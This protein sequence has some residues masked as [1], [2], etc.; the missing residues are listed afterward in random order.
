MLS[1]SDIVDAKQVILITTR[2]EAE[3]LGKKTIKDNIMT[4]D[5]HSPLSFNPMLYGILIGRTRYSFNLI[6]K[7]KVFCVNFIPYKMKEK[8]I[9]C[10]KQR[11]EHI[12]KFN[13][14]VLKKDECEKIDCPRLKDAVAF[15]EC[16]V[17]NEIETGD[18]VLF[19]GRVVNSAIKKQDKRL[20]HIAGDKFTTTR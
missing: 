1:I 19:V 15:L 11:G 12:D 6:K 9:Q 8:A 3:I 7:S 16:E 20:Y 14:F 13:D 5:W 10:G 17:E 4:A 18:H 2:G